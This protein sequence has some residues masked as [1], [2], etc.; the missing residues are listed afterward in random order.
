M[1][2]RF[3]SLTLK[4]SSAPSLG[5]IAGSG[6]WPPNGKLAKIEESI[7]GSKRHAVVGADGK[8]QSALFEE[9]LESRESQVFAGLRDLTHRRSSRHGEGR[10]LSNPP[11]TLGLTPQ[12]QE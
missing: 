10:R 11:L 6:R 4:S 1:A 12:Q 2:K 8:G 9:P 7:G 3:E 5:L